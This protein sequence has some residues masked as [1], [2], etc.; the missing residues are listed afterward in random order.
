MLQETINNEFISNAP[1]SLLEKSIDVSLG[2][3]RRSN[4]YIL[5]RRRKN[6]DRRNSLRVASAAMSFFDDNG[7]SVSGTVIDI[8]DS[9][10]CIKVNSTE[11]GLNSNIRIGIP[12][13]QG[14]QI[15]GEVRW[16]KSDENNETEQYGIEFRHLET[17]EKSVL[18][19]AIL[20]NE[21]LLI[22]Y[23]NEMAEKTGNSDLKQQIKMFFL[24]DIRILIEKLINIDQM[25]KEGKDD[26]EIKTLFTEAQ[27]LSL[28]KAYELEMAL[29]SDV[30]LIKQIKQRLRALLGHF[31]Y[32]SKIYRRALEKPRGYPG[33]YRIIETAYNNKELSEGIGKY[34]DWYCL[35]LPYTVSIRL[36]KDMMGDML[37]KY[38]NESNEENLNILNL[39]SGG[40]REIREMFNSPINYK[41]KA[42][43]MCVDQDEEAIEFANQKLS[44]IDTKNININLTQGNILRMEDL[45]LGK[46]NS[47]DMIY[48]IGIADY[49]QDKMLDKMFKDCYKLLKTKGQYI[50]AYKDKERNK[51]LT[52]NWYGDWNFIH[53]NEPEFLALINKSM[54]KEN[55]S[56]DVVREHTGVIFFAIITK[57]K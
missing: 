29:G 7:K 20:L 10:A 41:G 32:Q 13:I 8:S 35:G 44:E 12:L 34:F 39:A 49:L 50:I 28:G 53:R 17:E 36:R 5:T 15:T 26:A 1:I 56:I 21:D 47:L 16:Y 55:I 4:P 3:E 24:I 38:I 33:D 6:F 27:K 37:Y 18:R 31:I 19:K 9:G 54:G 23:A 57:L 30:G 46:E 45:D 40:C 2:N 11:T 25:I 43:I 14:N 51:P 52:F 22:N 42:N 48:S